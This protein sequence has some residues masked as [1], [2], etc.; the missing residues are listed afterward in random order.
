MTR[1]IVPADDTFGIGAIALNLAIANLVYYGFTRKNM[2]NIS[3]ALIFT[4]IGS[5]FMAVAYDLISPWRAADIF[6]VYWPVL[7][8]IGGFFLLIDGLLKR[9]H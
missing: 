2:A 7:L 4:I 8:I 3:A 5:A 1:R 9:Q 6:S